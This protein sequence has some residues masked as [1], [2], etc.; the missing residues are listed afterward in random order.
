[1]FKEPP[2][3]LWSVGNDEIRCANELGPETDG[4]LKVCFTAW[5]SG[6]T[7]QSMT[8]KLLFCV[9]VS[10]KQSVVRGKRWNTSC[11]RTWARSWWNFEGICITA[12]NIGLKNQSMALKLLVWVS[13]SP[14]QPMQRG[15]HRGQFCRRTL[16]RNWWKFE[17]ISL[18][19]GKL[20]LKIEVLL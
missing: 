9:P 16:A 6:L 13:G 1:M 17:G 18:L 10:S 19:L 11:R 20:A 2:Y 12:W 15:K 8:L 14:K 4:T 7:N 5:K 3:C